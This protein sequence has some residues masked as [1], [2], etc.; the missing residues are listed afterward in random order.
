MAAVQPFISGAISKTINM[1]N[2]ATVL[3]ISKAYMMSW[4]AGLKANAIY[5]DGSK[6]SQPLNSA[7]VD[8]QDVEEE[9]IVEVK[10]DVVKV[11][12]K[13]VRKRER[14]PDKRV[15]YTQKSI[16]GG[17]K[18]YLRTG[19]YKDGR[20]GEL[21][22]DMHKEGAAFRSMMNAYAIAVS[23]GLQYGV[24][25]EEYVDAFTFFKFEPAGFV[26]SHERI[27]SATSIIDWIWRDIGI[28]YL[29]REDLAHV[30]P[31]ESE[32]TSVGPGG[33]TA[34]T[35]NVGPVTINV[36]DASDAD[37]EK[38]LAGAFHVP[39]IKPGA[40]YVAGSMN[41]PTYETTVLPDQRAVA[42]M[43]GYTGDCCSN[44]SS[45]TM[46]RNGTCLKCEMCGE[47]TGCS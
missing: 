13:L 12:E 41:A 36:A 46:V 4:K 43:S 23:I 35:I 6:L 25:V 44:C 7:L 30:T 10:Q 16:V 20:L 8:D 37:L 40:V 45:F 18:V 14:M 1:P 3:D 47:T 24:P 33:E 21:F 2:D 5:R 32:S 17:H 27:K 29:G 9:T 19:E 11:V 22:I 26:Q 34:P 42:K 31:D 38:V 39:T 28:N 15:G